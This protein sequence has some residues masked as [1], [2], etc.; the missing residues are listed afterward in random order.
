VAMCFGRLAVHCCDSQ[1]L[2][3]CETLTG[4]AGCVAWSQLASIQGILKR[5]WL[6]KHRNKRPA[7]TVAF[8]DSESLMSDPTSY[9]HVCQQLDALRYN[10]PPS[11][12]MNVGGG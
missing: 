8:F 12:R 4:F 10:P 7:V 9:A 3:L 11:S 5:D 2:L 6:A 1:N